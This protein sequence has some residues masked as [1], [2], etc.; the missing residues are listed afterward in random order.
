MIASVQQHLDDAALNLGLTAAA[1]AALLPAYLQIEAR[2]GLPG[3]Q[4]GNEWQELAGRHAG[5]DERTED[6][7][8]V[9]RLLD[10]LA[11][12]QDAR[13]TVQHARLD[14]RGAAAGAP[15]LRLVRMRR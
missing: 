5:S 8:R 15:D 6:G 3:V 14:V 11:T 2:R 10:A 4:P 7:L 1:L 12:V 13:E 9:A